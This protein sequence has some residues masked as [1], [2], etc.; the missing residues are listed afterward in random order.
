MSRSRS[1]WQRIEASKGEKFPEFIK[2]ILNYTGFDNAYSLQTLNEETITQIENTVNENRHLFA[3]TIYERVEK[4]SFLLGHR[5]LLLDLPKS[6]EDLSKKK[7]KKNARK[8]ENVPLSAETVINSL[9]EKIKNYA[10]KKDLNFA[11]GADNIKNLKITDNRASCIVQ[12]SVCLIN[13]PCIFFGHWQISNYTKHLR[14]HY[15]DPSPDHNRNAN[16]N[17]NLN[18]GLNVN[19][20]DTERD[21]TGELEHDIQR[22]RSTVLNDLENLLN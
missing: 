10:Q 15:P 16:L 18:A 22:A 7:R 9:L 2:R 12:C 1:I 19:Q 17:A 3:N 11:I 8:D 20:N 14:S 21:Q 6:V 4:F 5:N 13:T